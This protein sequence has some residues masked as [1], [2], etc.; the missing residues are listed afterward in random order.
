MQIQ[1]SFLIVKK[2]KEKRVLRTRVSPMRE[3][4]LIEE[5]SCDLFHTIIRNE[6][7]NGTGVNWSEV[8]M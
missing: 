1:L 5:D 3:G 4:Y 6:R 8:Y 2:K 7:F